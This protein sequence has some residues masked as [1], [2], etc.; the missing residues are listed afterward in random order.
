M[1]LKDYEFDSTENNC[2]I[3]HT[4]HFDRDITRSDLVTGEGRELIIKVMEWSQISAWNY[5][6]AHVV[7]LL[8]IQVADDEH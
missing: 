1:K 8:Q 5:L 3:V 7:W 2:R 4:N 6:C